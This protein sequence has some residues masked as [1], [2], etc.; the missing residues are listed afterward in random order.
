MAETSVSE[1][2]PNIELQN[3]VAV[4]SSGN[5]EHSKCTNTDISTCGSQSGSG[6]HKT[7]GVPQDC[8][9]SGV[10]PTHGISKCPPDVVSIK[11][12]EII[13]MSSNTTEIVASI[14]HISSDN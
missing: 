13:V 5:T 14:E 12:P 11:H 10:E 2:R 3:R 1:S 8:N 7:E 4:G 6:S 9:A